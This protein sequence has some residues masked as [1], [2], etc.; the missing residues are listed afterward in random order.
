MTTTA[1]TPTPTAARETILEAW[2]D[3][4]YNHLD[5]PRWWSM[6]LPSADHGLDAVRVAVSYEDE[7]IK[8]YGMTGR[9]VVEWAASFSLS[10]PFAVIAATVHEAVGLDA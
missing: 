4:G 10:T 7:E 1:T 3:Y 6:D 8:V 5:S 2:G 9:G